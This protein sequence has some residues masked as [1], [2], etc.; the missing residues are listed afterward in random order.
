MGQFEENSTKNV[1]ALGQSL[2]EGL[3][4]HKGKDFKRE[5]QE[6]IARFKGISTED[7]KAI[8]SINIGESDLY[9]TAIS[10]FI[11]R[12]LEPKL[13]A[14][15][16]I[17]KITNFNARGNDSIKVPI[18]QNLITAT[19]L[20][21]DGSVTYDGGTYTST[22][23]TL[24]Y[25]HAAQRLTREILQFANVDLMSEELG[26]IG[27]AI[28]RKVDSDIIAAMKTATTAANGNLTQLGAAT[29]VTFDDLVDGRKSALDNNACPNLMLVSPETEA[30]IIKL[31][32]F[33]GASTQ[34]GALNMAS[35]SNGNTF[36]VPQQFLGMRF[37]VSQQVDDDDI[38]L[39]DGE[40]GPGYYVETGAI[41]VFDGRISG[42]V[43]FE[44]IGAKAYGVSIVQP[45]AI[46]RIEENA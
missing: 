24:R 37:A 8:E 33:T 6:K 43:A 4:L 36:P 12:K 22:T 16:A 44:V 46:F 29:T 32:E 27:S 3:K 1:R 18:R 7:T 23:V 14:T 26:Q 38:F 13:V 40:I 30:T 17:K 11:E 34:V 25:V 5:Q 42:T 21:D 19:D 15:G 28:A 20:P 31:G 9:T 39:I 35:D 2:V 41:E 10:D 45:K